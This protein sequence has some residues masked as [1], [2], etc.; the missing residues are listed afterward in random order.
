MHTFS[1]ARRP[2]A[3][4]VGTDN[5]PGDELRPIRFAIRSPAPRRALAAC[6]RRGGGRR[7]SSHRTPR[8]RA[9]GIATRSP[10]AGLMAVLGAPLASGFQALPSRTRRLRPVAQGRSGAEV[11][12]GVERW[13]PAEI[14][15]PRRS[16]S[17]RADVGAVRR[18]RGGL[19]ADLWGPRSHPGPGSIKIA[20]A[21]R[22]SACAQL[23]G[24]TRSCLTS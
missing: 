2:R 5:P 18:R 17:A 23:S 4:D 19:T 15:S 6:V 9:P 8:G 14:A 20:W 3:A 1:P 13:S 24:H 11:P 7:S 16:P 22:A 10:I 21:P 12:L